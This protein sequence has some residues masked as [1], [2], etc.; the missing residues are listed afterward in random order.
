MNCGI[1]TITSPSGKQYVGS[2]VRIGRRWGEHRFR[3][4]RGVHQSPA[5]QHAANKYG[6]GALRF[7][8][9]LICGPDHLLLYEQLAMDAL[10]P[11]Y[12]VLPAA[13]RSTG[14]RHT[15]EALAKMSAAQKGAV[16]SPELRAQV[17]AALKGRVISPEHAEKTRRALI[18][19]P[20]TDAHRAA[21]SVAQKGTRAS[22]GRVLSDE[23][24]EKI[25]AAHRGKRLSPEHRAKLSAA[26]AGRPKSEKEIANR[27]AALRGR[28]LSEEHR[29][30][31]AE[32]LRGRPIARAPGYTHSEETKAKMREASQRRWERARSNVAKSVALVDQEGI[33]SRPLRC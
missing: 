28:S 12:N 9:I 16:R 10:R 27:A 3:M 29:A 1:Y 5:L 22:V 15:P 25:A 7:D 19:K 24:K 20:K 17:S 8:V 18:G 30:K 32:T 2:S 26:G 11:A 4:R 14:Y 23:T 31:I 33:G 6:I 13:G 21:M